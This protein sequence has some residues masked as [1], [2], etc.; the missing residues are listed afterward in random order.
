M[1]LII[2]RKFTLATLRHGVLFGDCRSLNYLSSP[3]EPLCVYQS[4]GQRVS[5]RT[6][7][8]GLSKL[9]HPVAVCIV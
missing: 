8:S 4:R 5:S 1:F 9:I 7:A 6:A 2:S 3:Q